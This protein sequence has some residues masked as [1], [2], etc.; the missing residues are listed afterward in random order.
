MIWSRTAFA[1]SSNE[2]GMSGTILWKPPKLGSKN[3]EELST[4]EMR[5]MPYAQEKGFSAAL[6]PSF[7]SRLPS[8]ETDVLDETKPNEKLQID[9]CDMNAKAMWALLQALTRYNNTNKIKAEQRRQAATWPGGKAWKVWEALQKEYLPNDVTTEAEMERAL[10]RVTLRKKDNPTKILDNI[11]MI[12]CKFNKLV[13]DKKRRAIVMMAGSKDY[14]QVIG[15]TNLLYKATKSRN[16]TAEEICDEMKVVWRISGNDKT[17]HYDIAEERE[18][19]ESET[20]LGNFKGK[21]SKCHQ[22]GHKAKD[23]P[24]KKQA[25]RTEEKA[26]ASVEA[27]AS[28]CHHC[29]KLGHDEKNCW[30]KYPDQVPEWAKAMKK[31]DKSAAATADTETELLLAAIDGTDCVTMRVGMHGSTRTRD[32]STSV[33]RCCDVTWR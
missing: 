3:N 1:K 32:A 29:G 22:V 27:K 25:G 26:G 16:A 33:Q 2:K 11:A 18:Q 21:C 9:A 5:F 17:S 8:A 24:K 6:L 19:D 15:A 31:R 10:E 23:Y 7:D 13:T 12:E 28:K 20:A 14:T 30:K 4:W